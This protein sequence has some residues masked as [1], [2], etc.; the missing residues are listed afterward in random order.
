MSRYRN[1]DDRA[2]RPGSRRGR[3][4]ARRRSS[5]RRLRATRANRRGCTGSKLVSGFQDRRPPLEQTVHYEGDYERDVAVV[6]PPRARSTSPRASTPKTCRPRR[7]GGEPAAGQSVL[8]SQRMP[9]RSVSIP[10]RPPQKTSWQRHRDDAACG[11]RVERARGFGGVGGVERQ[12]DLGAWSGGRGAGHAVGC[13]QPDVACGQ[14][15]VHHLIFVRFADLRFERRAAVTADRLDRAV[16]RRRVEID[17]LF[18]V[19][20]E[21]QVQD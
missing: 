17:R 8:I 13:H 11:Q 5:S 2:G 1:L 9:K 4:S 16:Q 6:A 21:M 15:G 20:G 3:P 18:A 7:A 14:R 10:N 12:R 19:S